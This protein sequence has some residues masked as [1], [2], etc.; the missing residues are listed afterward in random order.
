MPDATTVNLSASLLS[1]ERSVYVVEDDV[2]LRDA[3]ACLLGSVGL[4]H[5]V[6]E[7]PAQF[8]E[9]LPLAQGGCVVLDIRL[10]GMSG[11]EL[12]R[13][14]RRRD[15]R[16]PM[17]VM[18]AHADVPVTIQAFKLGVLDFLIK[19]FAPPQFLEAVR[20][21]LA[22]DAARQQAEAKA[23]VVETRLQE[24]TRKDWEIIDLLRQ[25]FP[26]K[27]IAANLGITER[28]V[29]MRRSALLKKT[30]SS[31]L[32]ELMELIA[33]SRHHQERRTGS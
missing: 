1:T 23:E 14:I 5:Q 31:G 6:F 10:P 19:P 7:T 18:S 11:I 4:P 24:L 28:A 32:P 26:N 27:R 9:A 17:L 13:E 20:A 25:G 3:L 12:A 30:N 33:L 22:Q 8:L 29:E 21:A 15:V 2:D 16:L